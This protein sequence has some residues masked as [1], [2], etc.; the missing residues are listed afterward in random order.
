MGQ[1]DQPAATRTELQL[2][3]G[4]HDFGV[5]KWHSADQSPGVYQKFYLAFASDCISSQS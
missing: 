3:A 4:K 1:N 2:T 5:S